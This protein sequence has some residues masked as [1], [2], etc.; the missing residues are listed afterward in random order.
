MTRVWLA[1]A[2]LLIAF[3]GWYALQRFAVRSVPTIAPRPTTAP[4]AVTRQP[5]KPAVAPVRPVSANQIGTYA[6]R[7]LEAQRVFYSTRKR[8]ASDLEQL[9]L[10]SPVTG[11]T[12]DYRGS[13]PLGFCWLARGS[14]G[15]WYT[16]SQLRVNRTAQPVTAPPPITC[17]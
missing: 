14:Q 16:I 11:V 1:V 2:V 13:S 5:E 4:V 10:G 3:T 6:E 12:I 8:Y 7:V 17:R 9:R 15:V